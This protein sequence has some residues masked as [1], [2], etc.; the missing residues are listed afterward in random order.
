[1]ILSQCTREPVRSA[2]FRLPV[3]RVS[4]N[5]LETAVAAEN[6][7]RGSLAPPGQTRIPVCTIS[8]Q[9]KIVGYRCWR[10]PK[11]FDHSRFVNNHLP[12]SVEHDDPILL[13]ALRQILVRGTDVGAVNVP[14]SAETRGCSRQGVT[15]IELDHRPDTGRE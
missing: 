14:K 10:D 3:R 4:R 1:E 6:R 5:F 11:S 13:N 12:T 8:Y 2:G 7:T 9:S 15:V